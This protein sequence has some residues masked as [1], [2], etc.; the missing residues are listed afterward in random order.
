MRTNRVAPWKDFKCGDIHEG[1]TI[2]HPRSHERGVVKFLPEHEDVFDQWR[3][4]YGDGG[5][6]SRLCL[7]L[8][9]AGQAVVA[10]DPYASTCEGGTGGKC[11]QPDCEKCWP[12]E[13]T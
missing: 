6:L 1:D 10:P 4:D 9:Q 7:Q 8:G 11:T 5:P 13:P 12:E 3:V 2:L